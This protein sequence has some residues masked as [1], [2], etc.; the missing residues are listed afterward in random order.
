[1]TG[2]RSNVGT[3]VGLAIIGVGVVASATTNQSS[4]YL[5]GLS[6]GAL[7]LLQTVFGLMGINITDMLR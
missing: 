3:I 6:A 1:M 7:G 2:V 4:P 5:A